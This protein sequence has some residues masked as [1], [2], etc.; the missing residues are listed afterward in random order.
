E[1]REQGVQRRRFQ[2][3]EAVVE[4]QQDRRQRNLRDEL[5]RRLERNH[6]VDK[7]GAE[8]Q[9]GGAD[10]HRDRRD[11]PEDRGAREQDQRDRGAA[12]EGDRPPVPSVF[13]RSGDIAKPNR[14]GPG[15]RHQ[16]KRQ[17]ER[18]RERE[19]YGKHRRER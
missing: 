3:V 13:A 12:E 14:D 11:Q 8:H 10:Q 6:I 15:E 5:R 17:R 19:G 1:Q 9:G 2:P 4:E 18:Q 16:R 7:A